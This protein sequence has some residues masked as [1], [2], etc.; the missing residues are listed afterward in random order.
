MIRNMLKSK[1]HRAL[2][3]ET[4]LNYD[5][6]IT[7][8]KDLMDAAGV[9]S[10]EEVHVFNITN[11]NR[12]VTYA[13]EGKRGAGEIIVNGAAAHLADEGD[14]VIIVTFAGFDEIEVQDHEPVVVM[15][16]SDNAILEN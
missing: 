6:S 16:D 7:I 1:I 4:N 10:S 13:I 15:V 12:F 8:D 14:L 11:G 3:T 5:G 9:A 2:V